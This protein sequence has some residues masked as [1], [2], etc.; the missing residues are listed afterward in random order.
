MAKLELELSLLG[1]FFIIVTSE[2]T[3]R[4]FCLTR[5][6]LVAKSGELGY[7]K[8]EKILSVLSVVLREAGTHG[9]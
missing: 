5:A 8:E 6:L 7:L 3:T 4:T 2:K 9:I 1:L